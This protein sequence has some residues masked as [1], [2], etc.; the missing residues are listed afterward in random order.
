MRKSGN[1]S[2]EAMKRK[3]VYHDGDRVCL[4]NNHPWHGHVGRLLSHETYGSGW[5]GWKILLDNNRE[6][7]AQA[8]D[9]HKI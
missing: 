6:C 1:V 8:R 5:I 9:L 3:I 7:Y 4:T 2:P